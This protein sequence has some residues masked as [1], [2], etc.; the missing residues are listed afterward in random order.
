MHPAPSVIL[1][2]VLSGLGFGL[3]AFLGLDI[4][5]VRGGNA[6]GYYF[7]GYALAVG[8][9]LMASLHLANPKNAIKSFRQWRSSWL[10]REGVIAVAALIITA[11]PAIMS[12]FVGTYSAF[13]GVISSILCLVTVFCT[14]MIYAQ[15]RAIPRWNQP[16]TPAVFMVSTVA[17][18]A[19]LAGQSMIAIVVL[20]VSLV[21]HVAYWLVGDKR[22]GVAGSTIETA[23]GLGRIGKTRLLE[24]PHSGTNYLLSEMVYIVARRHAQK[25]RFIA[26]IL[27]A[28]VPIL[29]L[30]TY[31]AN[32]GVSIFAALVHLAG[33]LA[34]RWLFFAEAEHVV[35]LYYDKR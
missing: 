31:P 16:L 5:S 4:P 7:I 21:V 22:F 33:M 6:F 25:L 26:A 24:S 23:T 11:I 35:G 13:L 8:G 34:A 1:F 32:M 14:S 10:A 20:L 19:I 30:A 29:L 17:G 15:L 12:I 27:L 3:L 18:G 28:V 9:L 2:S